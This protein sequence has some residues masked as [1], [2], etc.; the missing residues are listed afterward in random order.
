M[1]PLRLGLP[2][3]VKMNSSVF[4]EYRVSVFFI[5]AIA[6]LMVMAVSCKNDMKRIQELTAIDTLPDEVIKNI[7]L[8][9]VDSGR[10]TSLLKS[11][12]L[13]T[14][15]TPEAKTIFP[16]GLEVYFYDKQMRITASLTSRFGINYMNEKRIEVK[17]NVVVTNMEKGEKLET[18]ELAWDQRKGKIFTEANIKITTPDKII[19]G[20][21]LESDDNFRRRIIRNVSGEILVEDEQ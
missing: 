9:Y 16:Q 8:R 20:R 5:T 4:Y 17:N 21:G 7:Q 18:E 11:P 3:K 13:Y 12:L 1:K 10:V 19:F 6:I 2:G 14:Y 15:S